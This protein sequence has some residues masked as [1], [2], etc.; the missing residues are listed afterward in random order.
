M[1]IELNAESKTNMKY[2]DREIADSKFGGQSARET[3]SGPE[4]CS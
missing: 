1:K 4:Q 3:H 2:P